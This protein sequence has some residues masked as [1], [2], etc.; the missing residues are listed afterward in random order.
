[1][2]WKL[3]TGFGKMGGEDSLRTSAL[4][5]RLLLSRQINLGS[6]QARN[7]AR[8]TEDL[9]K[10]E[11]RA[12]FCGSEHRWWKRWEGRKRHTPDGAVPYRE[13]HP[14]A[15]SWSRRTQACTEHKCAQ[16]TSVHGPWG[17]WGLPWRA[18]TRCKMDEPLFSGV[19]GPRHRSTS[20]RLH[21]ACF[22][23]SDAYTR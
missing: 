19:F 12:L 7:P 17:E 15:H 2:L 4:P 10:G 21:Q 11:E 3:Y 22:A 9:L 8:S 16:N 13:K 20:I 18:S 1:M 23:S 6:L 5:K 14:L